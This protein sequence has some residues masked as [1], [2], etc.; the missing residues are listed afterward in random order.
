MQEIEEIEALNFDRYEK[1][2]SKLAKGGELN[3]FAIATCEKEMFVLQETQSIS[4]EYLKEQEN[5][6]YV[7]S[8][9]MKRD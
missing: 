7:L 4:M 8:Q 1:Q 9:S 5:V 3:K 2:L 6:K